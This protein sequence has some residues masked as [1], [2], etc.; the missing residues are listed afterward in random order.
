MMFTRPGAKAVTSASA[1]KRAR[2]LV[3]TSVDL[4]VNGAQFG[5]FL[6][7]H[8]VG[9][10]H[11]GAELAPCQ[12]LE[13]SRHTEGW[14]ELD[15]NVGFRM[16]L[17]VRWRLMDDHDVRKRLVLKTIILHQND[18]QRP[19]KVPSFFSSERDEGRRG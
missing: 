15:M 19:G 17:P 4:H 14:I 16:S 10:E 11:A 8:R 1:P 5:R 9:R 2:K 12:I 18:L 7:G 6:F 3:S 13:A